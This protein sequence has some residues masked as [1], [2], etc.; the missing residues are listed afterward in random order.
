MPR[1]IKPV[2]NQR[3]MKRP[4]RKTLRRINLVAVLKDEKYTKHEGSK[5][6]S[7]EVDLRK[8]GRL[9]AQRKARKMEAESRKIN[10]R[11]KVAA[12][13]RRLRGTGS[14]KRK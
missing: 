9:V 2:F 12:H 6:L 7:A 4:T 10:R 11:S 8:S 1:K 13:T 5:P 3:T 14:R